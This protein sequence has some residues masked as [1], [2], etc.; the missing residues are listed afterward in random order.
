MSI[1]TNKQLE[2]AE[3]FH[4][5]FLA[6]SKTPGERLTVLTVKKNNILAVRYNS[7]VRQAKVLHGAG[8]ALGRI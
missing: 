4:L 7:R 6:K 5:D 3:H 2:S 8:V 1:A